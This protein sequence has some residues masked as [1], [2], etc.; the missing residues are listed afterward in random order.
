MKVLLV[1]DSPQFLSAAKRF[2]SDI[3]PV[4][5][6]ATARNGFDAVRAVMLDRPDLVLIDLNMPGMEGFAAL[7]RLKA[8][9][10]A[11]PVVVI[12]LNDCPDFRAAAE[13][14]GA[15]GYIAKRDFA[16]GVVSLLAGQDDT[17]QSSRAP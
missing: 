11:L 12:S 3:G 15:D 7:H 2:I 9:D 4:R 17:A 10:P 14:A 8:L 1:D 16:A 13:A 6:V 5:A